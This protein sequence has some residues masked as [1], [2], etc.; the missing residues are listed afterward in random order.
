LRDRLANVNNALQK[1]QVMVQA[2]CKH[3]IRDFE[4]VVR[5]EHGE[6]D[7]SNPDLTHISDAAG[8]VISREFPMISRR[9]EQL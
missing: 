9:V 4:Q 6:I 1:K 5:D 7:K 3:L 8:Y 2:K